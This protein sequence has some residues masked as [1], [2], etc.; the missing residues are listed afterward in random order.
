MRFS[1]SL[2]PR[3]MRIAPACLVLA[4]S[5]A[6]AQPVPGPIKCQDPAV[7]AQLTVLSGEI[8][9]NQK[10]IAN[11]TPPS[12]VQACTAAQIAALQS[13]GTRLEAEYQAELANCRP[14]PPPPRQ[15]SVGVAGIEVTQVVQDMQ[16]SVPLITG[17]PTW[18]RVYLS[19]A[20]AM[21]VSGTLQIKSSNGAITNLAS[22]GSAT[23]PANATLQ[24]MRTNWN[25]SLNFPIPSSLTA[26]NSAY[27]LTLAVVAV[28][29]VGGITC[30]NCKTQQV[31]VEYT[32]APP[33]RLRIV[34]IQYTDLAG[35]VIAPRQIDYTLLQSWVTRAYPSA[36]LIAT[37]DAT[38]TVPMTTLFPCTTAN[39]TNCCPSSAVCGCTAVN[40]LL[41][42]LRAGEI[43][44]SV[45]PRV[46]YY[47]MALVDPIAANAPGGGYLR[48]CSPVPS[49]VGSGPTGSP[50]G[51]GVVAGNV[52]G[53]S[54]TPSGTDSPQTFGD[55]YGGHELGHTFGRLHPNTP[56]KTSAD[57]TQITPAPLD[58]S[59]P[60]PNGTMS[61]AQGDNVGLDVGDK[62]NAIALNVI[63]G[64]SHYD[65]MTYCNQPQWLSDYTYKGIL[66]GPGGMIAQDPAGNGPTAG[67]T[68]GRQVSVVASIDLTKKTGSFTF[69]QTVDQPVAETF[70]TDN[71]ASLRFVDASGNVIARYSVNISPISDP[72]PNGDDTGL[73]DAVIPAAAG[74]AKL[75]LY[76]GNALLAERSISSTLP[77][78]EALR[79]ATANTLQWHGTGAP[80]STLTYAVLASVDGKNWDTIA[81]NLMTPSLTLS[82]EQLHNYRTVRVIAN[83]G[84]NNSASVDTSLSPPR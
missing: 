38:L 31:S 19:S 30:T 52:G 1:H 49:F 4:A 56:T 53:V 45:D 69:V 83:D 65:I 47:G 79:L 59:F 68:S 8:T 24:Q 22:N 9:Q 78:V 2:L 18:A 13:T 12:A 66:N 20:T 64:A 3:I 55:W 11:C 61:D 6:S 51:P 80:G 54:G 32:G 74:A 7:A 25:D 5:M 70:T 42:T 39:P 36:Q 23:L 62:T 67:Q 84:F 50:S 16:L 63:P 71:K 35:K 28:Q 43:T 27:T 33:V 77:A 44:T 76:L 37:V 57:C 46:H 73:V 17:K 72:L 81:L 21:T 15:A 10:D 82:A 60:Y 34:P 14:A 40:G 48:G 58:A 29:G 26:V 41:A 75:Q